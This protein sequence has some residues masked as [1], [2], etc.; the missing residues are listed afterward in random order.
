MKKE[1]TIKG[2]KIIFNYLA[3]HKRDLVLLSILGVISAIANGS[4]PYL[5]GRLFDSILKPS[6]IF[7]GAQIEIPLFLFFIFIWLIV[8][9]ATDIVDWRSSIKREAIRENIWGDYIVNGVARI[10]EFPISFHKNQK[11]GGVMDKIDRAANFLNTII[12]NIINLTPKFLSIFVAFL[13]TLFIKPLLS[14]V[15]L[16]GAAL[17]VV[18]LIK[19][20]LP[21]AKFQKETHKA[22]NKMFGDAYDA[23]IN[24]QA[25]KQVVA[26]KYEHKKVYKSKVKSEKLWK[27]LTQIWQGLNFYQRLII[28]TTQ[29]I[30]FSVSIFLIQKNQMTIGELIM[31]NGYA[32][33]FFTPFA[34]LGYDWQTIQNGLVAIER[35]EKILNL[36]K[37][38]YEPQRAVILSEIKGEIIFENVSFSYYKKHKKI[39]DEIS[40]RVRPGEIA[41]LVGESGVGKSTII[42]LISGFYF[43]QKG[44]VLIDGH[45]IKNLNLKFLRSKIAVVPQEVIL[46]NDTIRNNIAYGKFL[47]TDIEIKEAAEKSHSNEFIESFPKKYNQIVGERG[48][49][50][51]V[52]QKQRVAIARAIL[53]DPRILIL[54]EPTSAL[55]AKS[56]KFIQESLEKLLQGKTTFIIAHRLSTVRK[57]D[58]ILVIKD[59]KIVEHG[60]HKE[61]IQIPNGHYRHLYELQI[62]LK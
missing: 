22:Y 27:Q 16:S 37:E 20:V 43:S 40:F 10:L 44:K 25:I 48:I 61:L 17:C 9:L 21:A 41:A 36:P 53:R 34:R 29:L 11:M 7:I 56:E 15:L 55:D 45:N 42:D 47:A 50:L 4:V 39:L 30:V 19:L 8:Q 5:I 46:F 28:L 35:S 2:I 18:I 60:N 26:E 57:A 14:F 6:T 58:K 24:V 3:K 1:F 12:D 33:M 54:D 38:N 51:S 31:F 23:V 32:V 59:G 52:G 13:I 49:K 62:G